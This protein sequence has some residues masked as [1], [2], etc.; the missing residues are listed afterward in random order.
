MKVAGAI[1]LATCALAAGTAN[2]FDASLDDI[3]RQTKRLAFKT[4]PPFNSSRFDSESRALAEAVIDGITNLELHSHAPAD[5]DFVD[6]LARILGSLNYLHDRLDGVKSDVVQ[7]RA[8]EGVHGVL[9]YLGEVFLHLTREIVATV[10]D[11]GLGGE[12]EVETGAMMQVL[13][14]VR[15]DFSEDNC[16]AEANDDGSAAT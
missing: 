16:H 1:V 10:P 13:G 11:H 15:S 3:W 7:A 2:P 4:E 14:D 6:R 8:C 12:V 9:A 5:R